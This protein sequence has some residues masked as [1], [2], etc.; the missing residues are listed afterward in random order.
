[1]IFV[2]E[3]L[4]RLHF[5]GPHGADIAFAFAGMQKDVFALYGHMVTLRSGP[6]WK[7]LE[8][9]AMSGEL[10]D[11]PATCLRCNVSAPVR[12]WI[13]LS[14]ALD[15]EAFVRIARYGAKAGELLDIMKAP[16]TGNR[17]AKRILITLSDGAYGRD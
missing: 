4:L 7:G 11:T 10:G 12:V 3:E 9:A 14:F 16:C 2:E 15:E 13:S 17:L 1:M 8:A 5:H 6:T